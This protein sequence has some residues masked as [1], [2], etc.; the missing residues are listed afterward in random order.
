M[1]MNIKTKIFSASVLGS[2]L[3]LGATTVSA[4]TLN[5]AAAKTVE[6]NPNV[7]SEAN[8]RLS[9]DKTIDQ[10]RAGYRP[11]VDLNLGYGRENTNNPS[12]RP[13][14]ETLTRG[15]ASIT[16]RQMLFDGFETASE[17]NRTEANAES[18][19]Y[20]VSDVAETNALRAVEVYLNIL[21]RQEIME[22]TE[23]NLQ[24]HQ[25]IHQRISR[26]AESGVGRRADVDQID[27]RLALARTNVSAET[28]NLIDAKSNYIR[29][30]GNE[31]VS[32][33]HPGD[34]CCD[35]APANMQDA[36]NIAYK[37]HPALR[38]ALANHEAALSQQQGAD[39]PFYP[40]LDLEV[41]ATA[42]NNVEGIEGSDRSLYAMFRM[43]YNLLNGGADMARIE[44][45][46]F[47][48][49][50]ASEDAKRA[51]R[52]IQ[53]DVRLAWNALQTAYERIPH[54]KARADAAE[55]T[56][57]AYTQQFDLGQRTLLDLLD[58][59]NEFLNASVDYVDAY[60]DQLY[61][62]YW[63]AETMGQLLES[64][65]IES[66]DEAITASRDEMTTEAQ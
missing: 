19:G 29:V 31:P 16:G 53:Q 40:D 56:R 49:E 13:G 59:E 36:V 47:L 5:E 3:L 57:D 20:G 65:D 39:A 61:A 1:R 23:A 55:K 10:A 4:Q 27:A 46:E 60:Y 9:V 14:S 48:S 41:G 32:I 45:T 7:L 42:D 38:V 62:C 18:A 63:L 44:E 2:S 11:Q 26:R 51:K 35:R 52:E 25:D 58:S 28:G 15:E 24:A 54:L 6:S 64:M 34:G 12:T 30:V 8:R 43:N 37:Q 33:T 50:Q 22:L 21:R 17:V 66:R